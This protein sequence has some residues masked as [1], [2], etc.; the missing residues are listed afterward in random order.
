M[1][2]DVHFDPFRDPGKVAK[3]AAAP[4]AEWGKILAAPETP[5]RAAAYAA[6]E[7]AC[8]AKGEDADFALL[9]ASLK[10]ERAVVAKPAFVT[11][12][13]DLLVH[14]FDCR[15]HTAMKGNETY[16][17]FAEKTA[18]FVIR[19]V[20][21]EFAG[22]PVYVAMGNND[23]SCG[24]Y[25][26]D[27][28]DRYFKGTG[29]AV[30][31][32]IPAGSSDKDKARADYEAGGYYGALLPAMKKPTRLLMLDDI[33]LSKGYGTCAGK[34]DSAGGTA[35][36]SWLT[37]Q[38]EQAKQRGERV[39]VMGHIPPGVN[40]YGTL[41]KGNVCGGKGAEPY[42]TAIGTESLGDVIAKNADVVELALFGHTHMDEM[43]LIAVDGDD[44][45]GVPMKGV[46]SVSPVNGNRPSFTVAKIDPGTSTMQDYA[47]YVAPNS[48]GGAGAWTKEYAFDQTYGQTSYSSAALRTLIDGF[49][50][51]PGGAAPAS[52]AYMRFFDAEFPISPLVLGWKQYGC[53]MDHLTDAGYRGCACAAGQ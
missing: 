14:Q 5:G 28:Q 24:D 10:A 27:P 25:K 16:A 45:G 20:E 30:M 15:F 47:V 44:K 43:K 53:G 42:L 17:E 1:L 8:K 7:Q 46:A 52:A 34:A 19:S 38:L 29:D 33:Y 12:S 18:S 13:G 35:M 2:S 22:S 3:L 39:W 48:D 50:T 51:D 4:V 11:I 37:G 6:L 32:G 41:R 36:M 49:H 31:A 21:M 23:S 9:Q 26:M 40:V